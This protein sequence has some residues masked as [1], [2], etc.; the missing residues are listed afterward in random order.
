[1]AAVVS[2]ESL[3]KELRDLLERLP[4]GESFTVVDSR[5]E[6]VATLL[7][8]RAHG[9]E[10]LSDEEWFAGMD[11]LA[12]EISKAWTGEKDAVEAVAEQRR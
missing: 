11:A 10:T 1:M 8:L 9:D 7:S 2:L 6:P 12:K 3:G 4:V 5:G